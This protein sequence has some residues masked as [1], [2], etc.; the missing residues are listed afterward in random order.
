[1]WMNARLC[2]G[3]GGIGVMTQEILVP[4]LEIPAWLW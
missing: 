2:S 1:M 4:V 3:S